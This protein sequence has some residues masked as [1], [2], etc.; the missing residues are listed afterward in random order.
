[1][2]VAV[3]GIPSII[4][5]LCSLFIF[6]GLSL[7]VGKGG[8]FSIRGIDSY[9]LFHVL[10]G[11]GSACRRRRSGALVLAVAIWLLLNRHRFGEHL[12]FIGDNQDVA[13][14][15]G[16]NVGREKLKLFTL[17]GALAGLA[18]ILVTLE[19]RNFYTT[20]GSSYLL[21]VMAAV[22]IGGTSI[23]GGK[24]ASSARCSAATSSAAWR[25]ASS[26]AGSAAS[27]PGGGRPGVPGRG[28]LPSGHG[29]AAAPRPAA[30]DVPG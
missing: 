14:V 25:P 12:L 4:A 11:A 30:P 5:T 17:M 1:M 6:E 7:I 19:N 2:L 16:V 3:I 18:S 10:S 29:A 13:R 24:A 28:D 8:L 27:G 26:P 21:I 9:S 15:L 23:S 20:Q 22:F